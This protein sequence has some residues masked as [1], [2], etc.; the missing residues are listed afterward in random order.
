MATRTVSGVVVSVGDEL[1]SLWATFCWEEY[2]GSS[3]EVVEIAG[4][5]RIMWTHDPPGTDFDGRTGDE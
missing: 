2:G 5:T 1:Q 4:A 3:Q